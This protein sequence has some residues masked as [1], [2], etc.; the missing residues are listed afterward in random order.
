MAIYVGAKRVSSKSDYNKL[1]TSEKAIASRSPET[2]KILSG[3]KTTAQVLKSR[4]VV[5]NPDKYIANQQ[6]ENYKI[7]A[8]TQ[9]KMLATWEK[10]YADVGA[11]FNSQ[12]VQV[13]PSATKRRRELNLA[14]PT[15]PTEQ[16]NALIYILGGLAVLG[17]LK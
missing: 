7:L 14:Q 4:K 6:A 5:K 10:K 11:R 12:G 8:N 15:Q 1:S 9:A 17:A 2:K 3:Q 16:N 13:T